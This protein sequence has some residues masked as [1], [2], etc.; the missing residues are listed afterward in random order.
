MFRRFLNFI[1]PIVAVAGLLVLASLNAQEPKKDAIAPKKDAAKE[2]EEK[3]LTHSNGPTD[4]PS[5][6]A[7]LKDHSHP[8]TICWRSPI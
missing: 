8:M 6:L 2:Y 3:I 5:L 4:T 1:A 7:Y